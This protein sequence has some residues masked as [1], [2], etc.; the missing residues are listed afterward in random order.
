M[1][2]QRTI[3]SLRNI[4]R[5]FPSGPNET[6]T[7][8]DDVSLDIK[9]GSFTVIRGESG[10]G[11][12]SLL[13]ILGMLD[14]HYDGEY[15]LDGTSVTG[16]PDWF[17]DEIR[18]QNI[19][20]IFQEGRLFDHMSLKRNIEIPLQLHGVTDRHQLDETI[21]H[22]QPV[23]FGKDGRS[24]ILNQMPG[25]SSGGQKQRAS[26][27]RAIIN[28]PSIILAD[29]P[30][31]SLH[32]ELKAEVV[33]HLRNLC[34]MG[35]TVIVVS[36]D[37]VFHG[38][39]RQLELL[40]G[41][42]V[43]LQSDEPFVEKASIETSVPAEGSSI[44]WGWK[45][46]APFNI[47]LGQAIRDTFYRPI[48]LSLILI[49][50]IVGVCQVSVFTSVIIGAQDYIDQQMTEGSRLNRIRIKP[51]MKE[52]SEK[53]RFPIRADL[54]TWDNVDTAIERRETS[55][56]V[57]NAKGENNTYTAMGL[58]PDDPEYRLLSFVAGG[59]FSKSNDRPEVILTAAFLPEVFDT[60]KIA[61]GEENY[62]AYIGKEI[63]TVV[64]RYNAS[65][66]LKAQVPVRLTVKGIILHGE[67]GRQLYFPNRTQLIFD[68]LKRDRKDVFSLPENA[69][70]DNWLDEARIAEMTDFPWEDSLHVYS[71]KMQD[72]LPLFRDLSKMG[73][74]PESDIWKFKWALDI[75]DTAWRIFL[76]LLILIIVAVVIT[77]SANIFTSAKLRE[78]E[79]ALWRVLGMRRGDMVLTQVMATAFSVSV[80]ALI[81]IVVGGFLIRETKAMLERRALEAAAASGA[82]VQNFDAIFA[83]ISEFFWLVVLCA[84]LLGTIAALF[85]A[86]RT[87]NTDPAKVLQS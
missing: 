75:Q 67:G 8:V 57:V 26:V 41:K 1:S 25:P 82:E 50:L 21:A 78:R 11:K 29:E 13:R 54:A 12:T 36:H 83:P 3:I 68:S 16:R 38:V 64:N 70:P 47:L 22:L 20:F 18:A 62:D 17:L 28:T 5:S 73:Y 65:G 76:P 33:E 43:E 51:R 32:G 60:G 6:I 19:G 35:H 42:L 53:D 58:H 48:F 4:T 80:G 34:D 71:K 72:V 39:G 23:F 2:E 30:T 10:T 45:P 24:N 59:P 14:T 37:E 9:A 79:L 87:A 63:T 46:R 66:K 84:I 27:M 81:G 55:A 44:L 69:G 15:F 74:K 49:S 77:V 61:S 52:L 40:G 85:P 56:I 31:A 86:F 7:I